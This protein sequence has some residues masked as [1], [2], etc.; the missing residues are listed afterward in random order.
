MLAYTARCEHCYGKGHE[1]DRARGLLREHASPDPANVLAGV[2]P[3]RED[4]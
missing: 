3:Q 2:T 1:P 4:G